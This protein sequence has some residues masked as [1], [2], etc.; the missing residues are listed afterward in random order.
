MSDSITVTGTRR[1]PWHSP[2]CRLLVN[3]SE[4]TGFGVLSFSL[5]RTRY[6]RCDTLTLELAFDRSV[7]R[8]PYWFD[9]S[10]PTAGSA[11]SD[12]DI[13]LQM[14][15]E[16]T[17]GTQWAAV[18]QGIVDNVAFRPFSSSASI[19]CRDYLAKL[20]D[21]RV[22]DA[23]LNQ[24][25]TE[26]LKSVITAAGLTPNVTVSTGYEGQ[27]WQIEH[28]RHSAAGQHR[29]QTAFDLA[30]YVANGSNCDIYADGKTIVVAPYPSSADAA[31]SVTS[32]HY[33]DLGSGSPI[34]SDFW[35]ASF[36][37]DYQTAKGVV[38]HCI[39]WDSKQR[40]KSEVYFS[41]LGAGKTNALTNG[42][43]H[44]FKFP[45]LKQDQLQAK[46]ETLYRQIIAHDRTLS[47]T[48]HGRASLAPRQFMTLTG[49]GTTWD[50]T[51]DVDAVS[52]T[53]GWDQGYTQNVTLRTRDTAEDESI[54]YD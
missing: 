36:S 33:V 24:T 39:S 34:T 7:T 53:F 28:K 31:S 35:D 45:G 47:F 32:V 27:F 15:D 6:G 1:N 20:M 5:D 10:D 26:L 50:G 30:R 49:T 29:F 17:S 19:T 9:V 14:R 48:M 13:Q 8:A 40:I 12:I 54:E 42:T 23:W 41:A 46:A 43:M 38:V 11:L 4:Q 21:M 3:G 52:S 18:F 16:E 22:I 37:R 25:G 51:H 44:S 2:R